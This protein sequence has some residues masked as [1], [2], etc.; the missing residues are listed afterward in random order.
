L[1]RETESEENEN[2]GK[3]AMRA[4]ALHTRVSAKGQ[5]NL[6]IQIREVPN[7]EKDVV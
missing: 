3:K 6:L 2:F 4:Q 5:T 7:G 1:G